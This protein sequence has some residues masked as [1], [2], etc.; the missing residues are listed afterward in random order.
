MKSTKQGGFIGVIIVIII[1]LIIIKYYFHIDPLSF[2]SSPAWNDVVNSAKSLFT[3]SYN[4]FSGVFQA[5][6]K[7]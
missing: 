6:F 1:A 4:W 3:A 2:F 5:I 7:K